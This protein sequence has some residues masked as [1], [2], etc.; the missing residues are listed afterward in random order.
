MAQSSIRIKANFNRGHTAVAAHMTKCVGEKFSNLVH[1]G[2]S[3]VNSGSGGNNL[4]DADIERSTRNGDSRQVLR[5]QPF[6]AI[7]RLAGS[8]QIG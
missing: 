8:R 1:C 3:E 2:N 5:F 4:K 6:S 7:E